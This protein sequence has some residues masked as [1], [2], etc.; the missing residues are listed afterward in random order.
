M[1]TIYPSHPEYIY[2]QTEYMFMQKQYTK[3]KLI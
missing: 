2:I 3:L 1:A